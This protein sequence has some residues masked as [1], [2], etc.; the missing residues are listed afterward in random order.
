MS[1]LFQHFHQEFSNS[2][3]NLGPNEHSKARLDEIRQSWVQQVL[4][5][6]DTKSVIF[7]GV[8]YQG[9]G[10]AYQRQGALENV[11]MVVLLDNPHMVG[12]WPNRRRVRDIRYTLDYDVRVNTIQKDDA[13]EGEDK[14]DGEGPLSAPE[15][16]ESFFDTKED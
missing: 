6:G 3:V 4:R 14:Q 11:K 2:G 9:H 10:G 5:W 1:S 7:D 13:D 8:F 16:P 12:K 15:F